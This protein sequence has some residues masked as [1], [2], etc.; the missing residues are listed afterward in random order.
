MSVLSLSYA[1]LDQTAKFAE[2]LSQDARN[3]SN[4]LKSRVSNR[5]DSLPGGESSYTNQ[6][7][8]YLGSKMKKMQ[9]KEE[10]FT[11]V[12]RSVRE[13][14]ETAVNTDRRVAV[15]FRQMFT[16]L[17]KD[18]QISIGPVEAFLT[19]HWTGFT[20]SSTLGEVVGLLGRGRDT[21]VDQA[22]ARIKSWYET[23]GGKYAWEVAK[24]VLTAV[25]AVLTAISAIVSGAGILVMIA[26]VVAAVLAVVN[27]AV[28]SSFDSAA[29]F[30]VN[31]NPENAGE[32][33]R[34][35]K[36]DTFSDYLRSVNTGDAAQ[37]DFLDSAAGVWDFTQLAA[38]MVLLG[39]AA[40]KFKKRAFDFS[41]TDIGKQFIRKGLDGK[42]RITLNS[43]KDGFHSI[44]KDGTTNWGALNKIMETW[45]GT[46][47][48]NNISKIKD[49]L[50]NVNTVG[51]YTK[52]FMDKQYNFQSLIN[53][54]KIQFMQTNIDRFP[55]TFW[56]VGEDFLEES[57]IFK[58]SK[59]LIK[60]DLKRVLKSFR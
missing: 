24:D 46:K 23:E 56:K 38:D 9:Q 39:D 53:G 12:A 30:S 47:S 7:Q 43:I 3:Y 40:V 5:L 2:R 13:F 11:G 33:C 49:T 15:R 6:A 42:S 4:D 59:N 36:I 21:L 14:R 31:S 52:H 45:K 29:G 58:K 44:K 34:K 20:N 22:G 28:S 55:S 10:H 8:T 19:W 37:N 25:S 60:K 57:A 41:N 50:E 27:L 35:S 54:D 16:S 51:E 26:A 18:Q 17:V 32:A 48:V 1:E